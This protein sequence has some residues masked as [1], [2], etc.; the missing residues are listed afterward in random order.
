LDGWKEWDGETARLDCGTVYQGQPHRR[1]SNFAR[2]GH[3]EKDF[4]LPGGHFITSPGITI[5][6]ALTKDSW[7]DSIFI[8]GYFQ[9]M[10]YRKATETTRLLRTAIAIPA[11]A[12]TERTPPPVL[13]GLAPPEVVLGVLRSTSLHVMFDEME[14]DGI[15]ADEVRTKSAHCKSFWVSTGSRKVV[16]R[17]LEPD[18]EYHP[19]HQI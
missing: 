9:I 15:E 17:L 14:P 10:H 1:P 3:S 6:L 5:I 4:L 16:V 7:K 12:V 18:T 11:P 8:G 19:H 13:V 2:Y